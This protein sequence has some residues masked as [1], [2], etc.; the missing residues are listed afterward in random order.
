MTSLVG[1][2]ANALI[3]DITTNVAGASTWRL[4]RYAPFFFDVSVAGSLAV[5][6][7]GETQDPTGPTG[8]RWWREEYHL[9]YWE[10]APFEDASLASSDA[11]QEALYVTYEAVRDRLMKTSF[12]VLGSSSLA[13]AG[14][15]TLMGAAIGDDAFVRGFE[16]VFTA[17]RQRSYT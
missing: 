10:A 6:F 17:Q 16:L 1:T 15:G 11:D 2:T 12:Q 7:Q 13:Q 4:F 14:G 5:W 8:A 9:R 3:T